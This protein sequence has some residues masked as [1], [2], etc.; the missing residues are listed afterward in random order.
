MEAQYS[1]KKPTLEYDDLKYED[2]L[3][4]VKHKYSWNKY[5]LSWENKP[6]F[7]SSMSIYSSLCQSVYIDSEK[8]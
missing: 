8:I 7:Y 5:L 6:V 1:D 2:I 3:T 4:N